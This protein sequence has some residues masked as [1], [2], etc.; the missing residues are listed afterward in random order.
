MKK[1]IYFVILIPILFIIPNTHAYTNKEL[2]NNL[3][4]PSGGAIRY[5]GWQSETNYIQRALAYEQDYCVD[6]SD[7]CKSY[8][9]LTQ[10]TNSNDSNGFSYLINTGIQLS[11]NQNYNLSIVLCSTNS[12]QWWNTYQI[13]T[14]QWNESL[15]HY[16]TLNGQTYENLGTY[17]T[18]GTEFTMCRK[19]SFNYTSTYRGSVINI[20]LRS[21]SFVALGQLSFMGY[22]L[23][24]NGYD[25]SSQLQGLS[26]AIQNVNTNINNAKSDIITNNNNN[27][28]NIINNQNQNTNSINNNLNNIDNTMKDSS[29]NDPSN[30]INGIKNSIATNGVITQLVTLPITLFQHILNA[31]NGTCDSFDLGELLGTHIVLPCIN[32]A[33][34]LGSALWGTIDVLISGVLVYHVSKKFI[35]V[36]NHLTDLKEG[37][38]IGD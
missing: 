10:P 20:R 34:Y 6:P 23:E 1:L 5:Y 30:S 38:V 25:Y 28:Q 8:Y 4:M 31:V 13:G 35:K 36:F 15:T 24:S 17:T 32:V 9:Y 37:D 21:N 14:G 29:V 22:T 16:A 33:D 3:V 7:Y 26:T 19:I 27:T 12:N 2:S 18:D 11:A